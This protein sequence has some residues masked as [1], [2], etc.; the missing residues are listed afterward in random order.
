MILGLEGEPS[1]LPSSCLGTS[2]HRP[3]TRSVGC[4]TSRLGLMLAC[5]TQGGCR[6][7]YRAGRKDPM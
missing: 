6:G 1:F 3:Q 2:R 5:A 7:L 4:S